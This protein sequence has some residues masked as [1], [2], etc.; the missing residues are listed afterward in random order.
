M[1]TYVDM[2][3]V[4]KGMYMVRFDDGEGNIETMKVLKQ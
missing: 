4:Q 3:A 2:N 1:Q